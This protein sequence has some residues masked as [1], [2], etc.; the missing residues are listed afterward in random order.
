MRLL[1]IVPTYLPATRY[2]GPIFAV[3]GLCRALAARGHA[4]E[5]F[6]TSIDGPHDSPVPHG[7]PVTLDG[8]TVRYF[9]STLLRRLSYAPALASALRQRIARAD[10]VH[11]HSVFLWPTFAAA[12]LARHAG[13]PYVVSPRGMLV[14][15][16]I[17]SRHRLIKSAWIGLFERATLEH[18]AA[19]HV[20][21]RV[22]AAELAAFKWKLARV[23][24]LPNGVDEYGDAAATPSGDVAALA[25][26]QPVVLFLGRLTWVKGLD[27]LL[28]AVARTRHGTLVIAGPDYDGIAPRRARLARE[29][30]VADR[31]R[32]LPRTVAGRDKEAIFAA[33]RAFVLPSDSESFGN[34]AI[35]AMQR[36]VPAI[37]TPGVGA[38]EVVRE[39]GG[40]LVVESDPAA[41]AAA[42]DRLTGDADLAR[43]LG[44]AGRRH[45]RTHLGWANVAARMESLYGSLRC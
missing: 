41:L 36:G 40:G 27:R 33:A 12:R 32:L 16:L 13:V 8:V 26:E 31:V 18:A 14:K 29:L 15:R 28:H 21:S 25:R 43:R 7:V 4:V 19:V 30:G 1:H 10:A 2:G 35:E 3:H 11:L 38:A 23:E 45:V 17:A 22:E 5:V 6:T 44:D 39:A 42:I 20:T 9:K 37:V 24:V 34:A